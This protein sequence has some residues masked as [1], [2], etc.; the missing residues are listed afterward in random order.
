M[1]W[2]IQVG[3]TSVHGN[4]ILNL[5]RKRLRYFLELSNHLIIDNVKIEG[6][7]GIWGMLAVGF[8]TQDDEGAGFVKNSVGLFHGY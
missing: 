1:I 8:F 7:G 3:A 4:T 5:N 6:F 2:C